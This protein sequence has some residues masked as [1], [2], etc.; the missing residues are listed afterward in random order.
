MRR[1]VAVAL[2][3]VAACAL[4]GCKPEAKTY[5]NC[6][7]MWRDYPNGVRDDHPAYRPQLDRDHNG[8]ACDNPAGPGN[9]PPIR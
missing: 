5:A 1:L 8:W 9:P 4:A 2:T 3:A 7:A 6:N